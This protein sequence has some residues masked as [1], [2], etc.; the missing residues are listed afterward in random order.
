MKPQCKPALSHDC[1]LLLRYLLDDEKSQSAKAAR[2]IA[3]SRPVLITDIVLVETFWTLRGKKYNLTRSELIH[4]IQQLFAESNLRF[5]DSQTVW[6]A[7][8]DYRLAIP[9]KVGTDT[10]RPIGRGF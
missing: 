10:P 7:L 1:Y 2:L 8:N 5:E 3:G 9:V 4:V 6:R